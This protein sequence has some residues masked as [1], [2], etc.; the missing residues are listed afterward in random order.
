MLG[1]F[2]VMNPVNLKIGANSTINEGVHINCRGLVTIG[3]NVRISS[4]VQIHSGRLII[5]STPRIHTSRD[6]FI[7]DEVWLASG[8][9]ISSGVNIGKKSIIGANSVVISCIDKNSFYAGNP[10]K[11]IR[12]I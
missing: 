7:E 12:D 11:K 10:A 8:V 6:I 4:A 9:V 1:R 3:K 5:G 2:T